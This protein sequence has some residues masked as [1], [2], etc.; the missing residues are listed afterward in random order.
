MASWRALLDRVAAWATA[1][2]GLLTGQGS[3]D[4]PPVCYPLRRLAPISGRQSLSGLAIH[5]DKGLA[6]VGF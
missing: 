4:S 2:D 3:Y 6:Y 1:D 5:H